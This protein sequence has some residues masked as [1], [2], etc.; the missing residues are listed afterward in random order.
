[1]PLYIIEELIIRLQEFN[2][3]MGKLRSY[4]RLGEQMIIKTNRG[5]I[6]V[7]MALL[8]CQLREP[9]GIT[10]EEMAALAAQ[11]IRSGKQVNENITY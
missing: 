1:M 9:A 6:T 8:N 3:G 4:V 7:P 11:F 5:M 10:S 2:K